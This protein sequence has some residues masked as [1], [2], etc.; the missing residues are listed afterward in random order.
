LIGCN[1][2]IFGCFVES[3][4]EENSSRVVVVVKALLLL[5]DVVVVVVDVAVCEEC[6][7]M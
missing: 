1:A 7:E 3:H 5:L 2:R 6:H 4:A